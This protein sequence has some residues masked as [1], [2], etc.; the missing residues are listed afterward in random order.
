MDFRSKVSRVPVVFDS[1]QRVRGFGVVVSVV[2]IAGLAATGTNSQSA[3]S[4]IEAQHTQAGHTQA[5]HT[6]AGSTEAEAQTPTAPAAHSGR[7]WPAVLRAEDE[8][9]FERISENNLAYK[10]LRFVLP[11]A[12]VTVKPKSRVTK[13]PTKKKLTK[14]PATNKPVETPLIAPPPILTTPIA[15]VPEV[16]TGIAASTPAPA[17]PAPDTAAAQVPPPVVAPVTAPAVFSPCKDSKLEC[18][19]VAVPFDPANPAGERI[20]MFVSRR[21]ATGPAARVG[22]L[23]VNPGGPGGPAYDT[24]RN[25][26][27]FL[28]P[29]MLERFDVIGVDPR[30]TERSAP[31]KCDTATKPRTNANGVRLTYQATQRK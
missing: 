21:K 1:H 26:S 14:K 12:V 27:S 25:A 29:E 30:G 10:G 16:P 19:L 8:Q 22:A 3:R 20:D 31:L 24:V 11:A 23:F 9:R 4:T 13:Q 18:A 6:Q 7:K 5:G 17:P 28:T 15:V 2:L